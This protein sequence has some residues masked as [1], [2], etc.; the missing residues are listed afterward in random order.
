MNKIKSI[1]LTLAILLMS[2]IV[3]GNLS[4]GVTLGNTT[5]S[6][7][8]AVIVVLGN[9]TP[10]IERYSVYTDLGAYALDPDTHTNPTIT[11]IGLPLNTA[12]VGTFNITYNATGSN[13]VSVF[14]NRTVHIVDTIAPADVTNIQVTCVTWSSISLSWV[15]PTNLDF[16]GIVMTVSTGNP[17]TNVTGYNNK[18]IGNG[19]SYTVTGLNAGTTYTILVQSADDREPI[20][21][22]NGT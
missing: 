10:T 16:A 8:N 2:G 17:A 14:I 19:T 22:G 4:D 7:N 1:L 20:H 11:T 13:G 5:D 21:P 6:Q 3:T 12:V 9:S 18:T 15:N